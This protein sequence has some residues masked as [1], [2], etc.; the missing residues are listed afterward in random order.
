MTIVLR[1]QTYNTQWQETLKTK[2]NKTKVVAI[3]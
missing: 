2:R 1:K 3:V